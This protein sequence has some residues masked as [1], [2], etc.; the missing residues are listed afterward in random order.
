VTFVPTPAL[1]SELPEPEPELVIMP[2][3][4]TEAVDRVIP[5]L[6]ALLLFKIKL[7][8]PMTPPLNVSKAVPLLLVSVVPPAFA[9]S[10]PVTFI[11]EV[12]LF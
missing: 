8:V 7:P 3:R 4:F 9:V 11:A 2:L 12:V 1:I 6:V 5:L 10:A